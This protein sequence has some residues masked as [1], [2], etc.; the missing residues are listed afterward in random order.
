MKDIEVVHVIFKTHLDLGFTD[1]EENVTKQYLNLYIPKAIQLSEELARKEGAAQFVWTTGSWL[2]HE[3]LKRAD[4]KQVKTIE[5]AISKGYIAWHGLPFTTHTEMMDRCLFEHGLSL[6]KSLDQKYGRKTIAA[7]MT[8]VP[9]HTKAMVSSM[10][11]YGMEYLHLGVNPASKVPSVPNLFVW[12]GNDGSQLIVNYADNYGDVLRVDGLNEVMVFA[13]TGDNCG[14]PS[15]QDI[16][17]EFDDLSKRFPNAKIQASNMDAFAVKL[18]SIKHKLPVIREEIGDTWIHGMGTDPKKVSQYRE[19][20]RLLSEW[21]AEGNLI[22]THETYKGFLDALLLIPEHTWGLDEKKYLNDYKNYSKQDFQR[23]RK[24][25]FICKDAVPDKYHYIGSFAMDEFDNMSEQL[26][27][28]DWENRS[29]S[30]FE[31]SWEEQ[32]SYV[33]KAVN[34]LPEDK[35]KEVEEV[36]KSITPTKMEGDSEQRIKVGSCHRLGQFDVIFSSDGGISGLVDRSGKRWADFEHRLGVFTYESFGV[37]NYNRWFEQYVEDIEQTY[38]WSE[39][40]Q[41]KPGFELVTPMPRHERF[42]PM[43]DSI[44]MVSGE[45]KDDVY[46]HLHMPKRAVECFGAPKELQI[47]YAFSKRDPTIDVEV[48]WFEK[49]ANRLPEAIWYSFGLLVDNPNLWKMEKMGEWIS[50]L[51][52]VKNGNRN[53][54]A[55]QSGLSY[56]GADGRA[57]IETK[58]APLVAPGKPRL[59]QFDNTFESLDHGFHFNLYNNVW[60]TNFP[61]WYEEDAKFRFTITL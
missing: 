50:P 54:H 45:L 30:L 42:A 43:L 16:Q 38:R 9:G 61:M 12:E 46:V 5:E 25:N 13:H 2:I 24:Q 19:L 41:G 34:A 15:I 37:E 53:L 22:D 14:P 55:V 8:D 33:E 26:F 29:Y 20:L 21:K 35:Q 52:V 10:V 44:S 27:S 59:L 3:Y 49:E 18:R 39:A 40:D 28:T 48:N 31:R 51:E 57:A 56:H 7:K 36:F 4:E 58:D 23:A 1:L 47:Q 6:S 17:Q 60:G 11:K 32:R